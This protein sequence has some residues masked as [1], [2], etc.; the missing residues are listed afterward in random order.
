MYAEDTRIEK[1]C[2]SWSASRELKPGDALNK[3]TQGQ[4]AAVAGHCSATNA[5]IW[6]KGGLKMLE[7]IARIVRRMKSNL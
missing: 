5:T 4:C 1:T 3:D 6:V 2:R 7:R